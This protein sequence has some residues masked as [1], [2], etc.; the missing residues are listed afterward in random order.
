MSGVRFV[1]VEDATA[2]LELLSKLFED[3]ADVVNV[4]RLE[5]G[6]C[7]RGHEGW[8]EVCYRHQGDVGWRH[9]ASR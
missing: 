9:P 6:E 5:S 2:A 8:W 3:K 1:E 4:H 7:L